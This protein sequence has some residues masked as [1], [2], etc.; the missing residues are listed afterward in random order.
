M[1]PG[2]S[3]KRLTREMIEPVPDQKIE[4]ILVIGAGK[5]GELVLLNEL[6][7]A[8]IVGIEPSTKSPQLIISR[9]QES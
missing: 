8:K 2:I 5:G 9:M 6:T 1:S 4:N 3:S 7:N